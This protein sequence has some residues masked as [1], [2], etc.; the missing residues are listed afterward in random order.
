MHQIQQASQRLSP[1]GDTTRRISPAAAV[2]LA[3][4][5]VLAFYAVDGFSGLGDSRG[6][7]DSVLR[8]VNVRDLL[9]GQGWYDL[10]QYRLGLADSAPMH[11]SRLVDAPIATLSLL[12]GERTALIAWPLICF[13]VALFCL[14]KSAECL[15]GH[16][17]VVPATVLGAVVLYAAGTFRP[18]ALDHHNM[19]L[20]LVLAMTLFML[21]STV[22]PRRGLA[23]GLCAGV[24]IAIGMETAPYIAAIGGTIAMLFLM[25]GESASS[26]AIW[27]GAGFASAA[28]AAFAATVPPSAWMVPA[29]DAYS[30]FQFIVAAIAGIALAVACMATR[31]REWRLRAIGLGSVALAVIGAIALLFPQCL[32]DPYAAMN[33]DV[34]R[35][36]LDSIS[37]AQGGIGLLIQ[38][39]ARAI[40]ALATPLIALFV[41]ARAGNA[42]T[43]LGHRLA[44]LAPVIAVATAVTFWQVRGALFACSLAVIPLSVWIASWDARRIAGTHMAALKTALAWLVSMNLFWAGIT[45][46]AMAVVASD[47]PQA[48]GDSTKACLQADDYGQLAAL[49]PGRVASIFNLGSSIL[50]YSGHAVL[51]APYH[52]NDP[53]NLAAL[54]ML[55]APPVEARKS[56]DLVDYIAVCPGNKESAH[57]EHYAPEGLYSHLL[58]GEIPEWL[59]L[60]P[61]T[62]SGPIQLYAVVR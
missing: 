24:S 2:L 10:H 51:A 16:R 57:M 15:G 52:R 39:P 49:P 17:A 34:R 59:R 1:F 37:E 30:A 6:D 25:R 33:G 5:T 46:E 13:A 18:A 20:A 22:H 45:S 27:F 44:P 28:T 35:Y 58:R 19:Q 55:A 36:M 56:T 3:T 41:I 11:W 12:L 47:S 29:C 42:D 54:R 7:N 50:R 8:L 48:D 9:G 21:R 60:L 40:G 62:A 31:A 32:A 26:A 53:G 61:D 4:L 23:A 14:V 43:N 38:N